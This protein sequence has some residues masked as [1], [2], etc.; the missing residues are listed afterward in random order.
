MNLLVDR[1][2]DRRQWPFC[3]APRLADDALH[4]G[5]ADADGSANLQD[6]HTCCPEIMDAGFD[7]WLRWTPTEPG[8]LRSGPRQ[9]GHDTLSDHRSFEFGEH[10]QHLKHRPA[11]RRAG[12]ETLL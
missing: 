12:V 8:S 4:D 11:G 3:R 5:S 6:A 7:R 2:P 1:Q 10:A 9:P